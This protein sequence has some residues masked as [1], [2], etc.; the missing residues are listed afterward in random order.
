MTSPD[1]RPPAFSLPLYLEAYAAADDA[2]AAPSLAQVT[3]DQAF[4]DRLR[5]LQALCELHG[6][7]EVRQ[8]SNPN[9]GPRG[10]EDDLSLRSHELVVAGGS[11]WYVANAKHADFYVETRLMDI[12][13]L[14]QRVRSALENDAKFVQHGYWSEETA[15][16]EIEDFRDSEPDPPSLR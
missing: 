13:D 7:S 14:E 11:F 2:D 1:M 8:R 10:I 16:A 9:W 6:L 5:E 3:V 4:L 12:A 15:T